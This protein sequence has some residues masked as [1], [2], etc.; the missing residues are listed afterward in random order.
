MSVGQKRRTS[1]P[2]RLWLNWKFLLYSLL[3]SSFVLIVSLIIQWIV[4]DD[5][6]HRTGPLRIV[7]TCI[8][9]LVT[10]GAVLYWQ[11]G[12][13]Q[14]Q[15]EMIRRVEMVL[16]MND[17]IRNALQAIQCITY[18]SRP[19]ETEAVR[20]SVNNIDTVL[21]EILDDST[22]SMRG[23]YLTANAAVAP[24]RRRSA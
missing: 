11:H 4:Y 22:L 12:I 13:E 16:H 20:Q 17:R 10:F 23:G 2:R 14:R 8:A 15:R 19:E 18:L 24:N 7:G 9:A 21:R 1:P 3:A 5:W 6:L